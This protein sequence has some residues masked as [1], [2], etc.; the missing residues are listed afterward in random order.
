MNNK[1][2]AGEKSLKQRFQSNV[3]LKTLAWSLGVFGLLALGYASGVWP[4][5][6]PEVVFV[7]TGDV[8]ARY[9]VAVQS[10]ERFQKDT[11][12]WSEESRKLE[13]KMKE[14]M[15]NSKPSDLKAAEEVRQ[16]SS[17]LRA[18]QEK[19]ARLDQELM[20]PVLAE[21]NAGIKKFAQKRGYKIVLG[22]LQGGVIL[23]GEEGVDVT[24]ALIADLNKS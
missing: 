5:R 14:V 17:R 9:K 21:L 15:K 6:R 22:T 19:G 12:E 13:A 11:S 1:A 10:R 23:H 3:Y 4:S 7:R 18:L 16:L 24:E 2:T 8:M 20:A